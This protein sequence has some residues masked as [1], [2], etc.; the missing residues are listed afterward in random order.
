MHSH[1]LVFNS[2]PTFSF[3]EIKKIH[4]NANFRIHNVAKWAAFQSFLGSVSISSPLYLSIWLDNGKDSLLSSSFFFVLLLDKHSLMMKFNLLTRSSHPY[5]LGPRGW[6]KGP[7]PSPT[8]TRL[9]HIGYMYTQIYPM[10]HAYKKLV[11]WMYLTKEE[12][13]K[14]IL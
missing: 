10:T 8:F 14:N 9:A 5:L 1:L 3:W 6:G 4:E 11:G 7:P 12:G 2:I 13:K